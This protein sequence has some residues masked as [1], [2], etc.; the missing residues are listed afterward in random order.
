MSTSANRFSTAI[1]A[2]DETGPGVKGAENRFKKLHQNTSRFARQSAAEVRRSGLGRIAEAFGE[3]EKATSRVFGTRSVTSGIAGRLGG[4]GQASR[5]AGLSMTRAAAQGGVLTT[6]FS[7]L[8]LVVGGTVGVLAAAG[9]A[10]VKLVAGWANSGAQLGRLSANL[11]VATRDLQA[12][13]GAAERAGVSKDAMAGAIGGIG[14]SIHAGIYGQNPEALAALNK[15]GIPIKRK[16][17][18]TVDVA[19][20]TLALADATAKIKDPYAQQHLASIFGFQEALPA[21]RK[22]GGAMKADM[23]DVGRIGG[24][25]SDSDIA[26]ASRIQREVTIA[27]QMGQGLAT[28]G[29]GKLAEFG[30]GGFTSLVEGGRRLGEGAG[31]FDRTVTN[32]FTP[33]VDRLANAS[34]FQA[35]GPAPRG[36]DSL[37]ARIEHQESRGRQSAVSSAGAIGAM[38][39]MPDTARAAAARLGVPFDA[40]R[41]R[42]DKAYNQALG[43]EELRHLLARYG[44]DELLASAAYNAGPGAVDKWIKRFGDPRGGGITPEEFASQIPFKE[45]RDYVQKV[46]AVPPTRLIH[47]FRGLPS[48]ATVTTRNDATGDVSIGRAMPVGP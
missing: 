40:Q 3:L 48:G 28:Q 35:P 27:K 8:G 22:G 34:R 19:A 6:M 2:T 12:F 43:R 17:D 11:G 20:M 30:E 38:Q 13:Q 9:V 39:L 16:A 32:R 5:F 42:T 21:F 44:G 18:G 33:A 15:L 1:T 31:L 7:G 46:G 41:L 37:A 47:E 14:S 36:L 25:M 24:I 10:S 29:G 26:R 45:T 4:I 23:A